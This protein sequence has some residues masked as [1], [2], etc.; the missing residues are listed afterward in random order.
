MNHSGFG[1]RDV[2]AKGSG[3]R[4]RITIIIVFI[5]II[6]IITILFIVFIVIIALVCCFTVTTI[7]IAVIIHIYRT[8]H[9]RLDLVLLVLICGAERHIVCSFLSVTITRVNIHSIAIVATRGLVRF[10]RDGS[11]LLRLD[12]SSHSTVCSS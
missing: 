3:K 6:I 2:E 11:A 9:F 12:I 10:D 5:I 8:S 7:R 4:L 1:G